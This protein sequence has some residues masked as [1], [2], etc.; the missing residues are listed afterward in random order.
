MCLL[1]SEDCD[2]IWTKNRVE[3]ADRGGAHFA[4][5]LEALRA[6]RHFTHAAYDIIRNDEL[7][8]DSERDLE[9]GIELTLEK[10]AARGCIVRGKESISRLLTPLL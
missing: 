4:A 5:M 7:G 9:H 1:L 2:V 10:D 6:S 3:H 8:C